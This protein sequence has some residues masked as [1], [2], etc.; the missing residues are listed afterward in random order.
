MRTVPDAPR[1]GAEDR[2]VGPSTAPWGY[3]ELLVLAAL[4]ALCQIAGVAVVLG[5]LGA[6]GPDAAEV[7][8]S[9]AHVAIPLQMAAWVP[10]LAYIAYVV[11]VRWRVPLRTGLAWL[12]MRGTPARYARLGLLLAC[13]SLLASI[14]IG[15]EGQSTPMDAILADPDS[16][17]AVVGF[18]VL[19]APCVEELVFRGF[20]FGS[21]ER[22]HGRAVAV[23]A[24]SALFAG[25]HG[26]QYGWQAPKLAVLLAVGLVLGAVRSHSGSTI[27][28]TVVHTAYNAALLVSLGIS[29]AGL[30]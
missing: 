5:L 2:S 3:R 9:Q 26:G 21:L 16:L 11:S 17:W 6:D 14:A 24:T 4:G 30:G 22:L 18:G 28:S 29:L 19:V 7:L 10:V 23:A 13:G 25:L 8:L 1:L 27:A 12:P 20:L 15:G